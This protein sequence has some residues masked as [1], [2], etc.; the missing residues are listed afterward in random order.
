MLNEL[1]LTLLFIKRQNTLMEQMLD[2]AVERAN[3]VYGQKDNKFVKEAREISLAVNA[4]GE[5][6]NKLYG[7]IY[8][9]SKEETLV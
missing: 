7:E 2:R 4:L 5:T 3:H 6:I 9:A 1:Y 8:Y